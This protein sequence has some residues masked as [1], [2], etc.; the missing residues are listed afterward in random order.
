MG[1]RLRIGLSAVFPPVDRAVSHLI[2][3]QVAF[4]RWPE[5]RRLDCGRS[6]NEF[7]VHAT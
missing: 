5:M 7:A 1:F 3:G 6:S 2:K 4:Y